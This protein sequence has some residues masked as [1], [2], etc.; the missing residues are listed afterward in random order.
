MTVFLKGISLKKHLVGKNI[1]DENNLPLLCV[2]EYSQKQHVT[3]ILKFIA[4]R[5]LLANI[6]G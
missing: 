6:D 5:Y 1:T 2:H 3:F 4:N